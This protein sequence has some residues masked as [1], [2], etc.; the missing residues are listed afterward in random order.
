MATSRKKANELA[1]LMTNWWNPEI[2]TGR[3]QKGDILH[4]LIFF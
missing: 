1:V 3:I 4:I 2:K